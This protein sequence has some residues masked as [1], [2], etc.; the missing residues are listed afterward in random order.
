MVLCG[1]ALSLLLYLAL[2]LSAEASLA[3]G[4][5]LGLSSTAQVLPMLRA[6]HELNT[7]QGERA[8][9]VL[10]FQDLSIVPLI[11]IIAALSRAPP[12]P[13]APPGWLLAL[14]TVGAI[15]FLVV[16][17]RFV[18]NPLFRL[19]GR[20]SERELFVDRRLPDR[21]F[22]GASGIAGSAVAT[23]V[24]VQH[25]PGG[26]V[27]V[28]HRHGSESARRRSTT[29]SG[30]ALG[31]DGDDPDAGHVGR[32]REGLLGARRQEGL[33]FC[34]GGGSARPEEAAHSGQAERDS[35]S[36]S[37]AFESTRL[38]RGHSSLGVRNRSS[39]AVPAAARFQLPLNL[40]LASAPVGYFTRIRDASG[41][42][43]A[44]STASQPRPGL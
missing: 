44:S 5:P 22:P 32:H 21:R 12:D 14:Y 40:K 39:V 18:I 28:T 42:L 20:V 34:R 23:H 9:S 16:A 4:L 15:A 10:L 2:G 37:H 13:L 3:I 1:L 31:S 38:G 36:T 41:E 33:S 11:T 35:R 7:A 25:I 27:H 30:A 43:P 29:P 24:D 19:V 26:H 17:G 8:F 6:D